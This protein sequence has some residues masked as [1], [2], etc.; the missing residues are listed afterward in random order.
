MASGKGGVGK[1]TVSLGLALALARQGLRVGLLDGDLTG[2]SLA[3]MVG[4]PTR[5]PTGEPLLPQEREGLQVLSLGSFLDPGQSCVLRGPLLSRLLAQMLHE[6]P[7]GPL[8]LL[9]VDC[10]PGTG[11]VPLA[12]A[13]QGPLDGALLVSTPQA[14]ALLD[15]GRAYHMFSS[16]QVPL[17]GL[18]ENMGQGLCGNCACPQELFV[19]GPLEDFAREKGLPLLA[20]LPWNLSLNRS[21]DGGSPQLLGTVGKIFQDLALQLSAALALEG[22]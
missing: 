10:P 21:H 8:D 19:R 12:L 3:H 5:A 7:W 11:D 18:V 20:R 16:L 22:S 9:V 14:L 13:E 1:S 6:V 15:L 2:P 17:V 4:L